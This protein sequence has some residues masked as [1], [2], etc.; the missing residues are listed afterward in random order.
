MSTKLD[1]T[2]KNFQLCDKGGNELDIYKDI[3]QYS[4]VEELGSIQSFSLGDESTFT[5]S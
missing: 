2:V 4:N 5:R 3:Q 1:E